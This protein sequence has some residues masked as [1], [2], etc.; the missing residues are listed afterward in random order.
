MEQDVEDILQKI[1]LVMDNIKKIQMHFYFQLIIKI[2]ILLILL[3]HQMLF[4]VEVL[5]YVL[6]VMDMI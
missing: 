3:I 5:F 2:N 4:I 6:L 1:G